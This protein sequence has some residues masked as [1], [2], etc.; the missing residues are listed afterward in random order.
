MTGITKYLFMSIVMTLLTVVLF[1]YSQKVAQPHTS[2]AQEGAPH[3][4]VN[5]AHADAVASADAGHAS[6]THGSSTESPAETNA[7]EAPAEEANSAERFSSV[8]NLYRPPLF[9]KCKKLF[10]RFNR[11]SFPDK[12]YKA[13]VYSFD[14]E[15]AYC[16]DAYTDKGQAAAEEIVLR[17]CEEHHAGS[18][19]YSPC[20]IYSVE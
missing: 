3:A 10:E 12:P 20:R 16:A 13:F 18:G 11:K 6:A 5:A 4:D 14:G 8:A 15:T 19:K 2:P 7:S 9:G 1:I 17:E